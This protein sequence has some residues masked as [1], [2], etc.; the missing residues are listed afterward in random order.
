MTNEATSFWKFI[1]NYQIE[2]PTMHRADWAKNT[3]ATIFS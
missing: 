2:I 1:G 3:C